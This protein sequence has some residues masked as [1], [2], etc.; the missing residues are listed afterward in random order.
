M[1]MGVSHNRGFKY[2]PQN[3][4]ALIV[5]TPTNNTPNLWKQP[6]GRASIVRPLAILLKA[7]FS[8]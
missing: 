7:A 5:R 4:K 3:S 2:R 6:N 8:I 1:E